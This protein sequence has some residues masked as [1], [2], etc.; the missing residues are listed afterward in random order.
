L[1][2]AASEPSIDV[3][4]LLDEIRALA[5]TGLHYT[6]DPFDRAR[7]ER[8]LDLASQGYADVLRGV[9]D[10][11]RARFL[12]QTG[13]ATAKVGADGAAF[14]EHARIL[15]VR[16]AD[17]GAWGLVA[18]WVDPNESPEDTLVREF[19]EEVGVD[20]RVDRL[21]AAFY[22]TGSATEGPHSVISLVYLCSV[23]QRTFTYQ[24][25]EVL[26]AGWY[27]IDEITEWHLNHERLARGAREAWWRV[28][29]G[30]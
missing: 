19:R 20:A 7:Y 6:E 9:P 18:G 12:A 28:R 15:L 11:L 17:D 21:A 8:L 4:G 14:D 25:H 13:Y 22:R 1:A 27:D 26:E 2:D 24:P 3:V 23:Q 10:A 16:R 30:F 5:R 29:G